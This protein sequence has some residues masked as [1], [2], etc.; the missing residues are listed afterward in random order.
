VSDETFSLFAILGSIASAAALYHLF[1]RGQALRRLQR[2][3]EEQGVWFGAAFQIRFRGLAGEK[4]QFV[5]RAAEPELVARARAE[6]QKPIETRLHV[7]GTLAK[8]DGG[9]NRPWSWHIAPDQWDLV[10]T[11][12][13]LCDGTPVDVEGNLQYW[14]YTVKRFCPWTSYLESELLPVM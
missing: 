3:L 12:I 11:S 1:R 14:L 13:E 5:V 4:G 10:E 8:G 6:L 7:T 2:S 9:F